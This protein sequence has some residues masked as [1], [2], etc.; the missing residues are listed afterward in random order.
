VEWRSGFPYSV[1]DARRQIVGTPN[2][3]SFPAF[4]SL[5][6]TVDKTLTIKRKRV[7]LNVQLFNA[8]NH[9][10]PRDVFAVAGAPRFGTFVNSVGP[11]LRG[12]IG[13]DW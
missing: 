5:D 8:T 6:L 9:S 13:V 1:L 10:N 11:T 12:D 2:S 4:F 3:S 7:K